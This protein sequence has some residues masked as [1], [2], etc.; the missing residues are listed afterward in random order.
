MMNVCDPLSPFS[1]TPK[2]KDCSV[3]TAIPNG[4]CSGI[5]SSDESTT[6]LGWG[7]ATE[8]RYRPIQAVTLNAKSTNVMLSTR[9]TG[10][11]GCS[12]SLS[13]GMDLPSPSWTRKVGSNQ[14][15]NP[16]F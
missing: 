9:Y 6:G 14:I 2:L 10:F 1:M 11:I 4:P 3:A 13:Y 15:H 7:V 16:G 12:S 8:I 5:G